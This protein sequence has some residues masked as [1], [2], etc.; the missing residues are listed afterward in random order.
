MGLTRYATLVLLIPVTLYYVLFLDRRGLP[1]TLMT[2]LVCAVVVAPWLVRNHQV[3][4]TLFGVPGVA[5][6]Q[7]TP[8]S[9]GR[10][11]SARSSP[12]FRWSACSTSS[13]RGRGVADGPRGDLLKPGGGWFGAFFLV[14]LVGQFRNPALNRMRVFLFLSLAAL[15][16]AQALG[17]TYLSTFAPTLNSENL[18]VLL[19]PG[20][21]LVGVGFYDWLLGRFELPFLEFRHVIST[22]LVLGTGAPLLMGFLPPRPVPIAYPP[23]YPPHLQE[24]SQFLESSELLLT[25]MPWAT[26]WYGDRQSV[27]TPLDDRQSFFRIHDE[28]KKV[29]GLLLTPLTTDAAFRREILQGRDHAWSRF[30]VEVMLRT[31]VAPGFPLRQ[32]WSYGAPDHLLL[33]DRPRWQASPPPGPRR[34]PSRRQRWRRS[35]RRPVRWIRA[36]PPKPRPPRRRRPEPVAVPGSTPVRAP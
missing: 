21:F 13:G 36:P 1:A 31:N 14:G 34:N 35:A 16:V 20:M 12:I 27:W 32:A 26:A 23:Y 7:E 28:H 11:S 17:R 29:S 3:S 10:A 5:I 2:W 8:G 18:L 4:G 30:A 33:S 25:D 22:V 24:A 6:Y 19:T 9:R 15:A